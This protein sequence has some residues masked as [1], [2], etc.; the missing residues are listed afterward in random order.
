MPAGI[1]AGLRLLVETRQLEVVGQARSVQLHR[2]LVDLPLLRRL[3]AAGVA[4]VDQDPRGPLP[5]EAPAGTALGLLQLRLRR[6]GVIHGRRTW[7]TAGPMGTVRA[8][9]SP[10]A[11]A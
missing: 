5:V 4:G 11:R 7:R 2:A 3:G 6:A 10:M 9:L 1:S 8:W